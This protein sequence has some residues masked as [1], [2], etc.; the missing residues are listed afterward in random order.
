MR[1]LLVLAAA[2]FLA[3]GCAG[4]TEDETGAAPDRGDTTVTATDT[5][6]VQTDT[7]MGA[8]PEPTVTD[9]SAVTTDTMTVDTVGAQGEIQADT[10]SWTADTSAA[11]PAD[12][13]T[14]TPADTTTKY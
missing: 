1:H 13:T 4:R 3:V 9:T 10:T 6:A 14:P 2:A 11:V 8:V 7:T 12:T 5:T